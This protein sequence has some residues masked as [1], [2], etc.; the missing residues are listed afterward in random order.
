MNLSRIFHAI[1][2]IDSEVYERTSNRRSL[3]GN[4]TSVGIKAAATV[5]LILGSSLKSAYGKGKAS[6]GE[7]LNY[8]LTLEYLEDAF[9]KEGLMADGLIP[10]NRRVIFQQISKHESA[11][12]EFLLGVLD[13][14]DVTPVPKPQFDFTANGTYGTVW[15]DYAVFLTLSQAFEDTGVRAYKG[16]AQELVGQAALTAALQIHSV[17]AR[18]A[19]MIRR[20]RAE[21][22]WITGAET[23]GVPA[24]VYA[25]ENVTSQGG[26]S[27]TGLGISEAA[28]T[29]AFDEPL[30]PDQVLAIAN[31][32]IVVS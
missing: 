28:A 21:K 13:S 8:A 30:T 32:F 27:I 7:V 20:L 29:Q 18:H 2:S 6:V 12:V 26:V 15:S 14:M 22:G 4:L 9:Y 16:R 23:N 5:P 1:G 10:E 3:F 11:H 24:A 25:G 19:A 17:E 31:P